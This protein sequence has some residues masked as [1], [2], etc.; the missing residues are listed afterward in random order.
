MRA[1]IYS[2]PRGHASNTRIE[3]ELQYSD[4]VCGTD[5]SAYVLQTGSS[6]DTEVNAMTFALPDCPAGNGA[7]VM[8]V[9]L[10]TSL[11]AEIAP[12]QSAADATH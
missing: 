5:L 10:M 2:T 7:L 1:E 3:V 11:H 8:Q 6:A 4:S 12:V 9:P